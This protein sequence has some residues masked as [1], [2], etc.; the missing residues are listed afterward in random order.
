VAVPEPAPCPVYN[1]A[2]MG[3]LPHSL[4]TLGLGFGAVVAA[5][6]ALAM[7]VIPSGTSPQPMDPPAPATPVAEVPPV[8]GG[9]VT[10]PGGALLV[11]GD[12]EGLLRLGRETL[13][14]RYGLVGDDGGIFFD[15]NP[16]T[17][18]RIQYEGLEFFVGPDDCSIEPGER[19]DPSGVTGATIRCDD[20]EDVRANGTFTFEGTVGVAADLLGMRG[21]IPES[22]GVV[23]V[24]DERLEFPAAWVYIG[25]QGTVV[26]RGYSLPVFDA[27]GEGVIVFDYD[28]QSHELT[29]ESVH[30]D[31]E[32]YGEVPRGGC[33][34]GTRNLGRL[35]AHTSVV[36][37]VI[38]CPSIDIEELGPVP[39]SGTL[40]LE[41]AELR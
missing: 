8:T 5:P 20:V 16:L 10:T 35:N 25:P 31:A 22:G 32:R 37:V 18:A 24:G 13:D 28:P 2:T 9:P 26:G 4:L 29:L 11:S 34:L 21:G 41:R 27:T 19:H 6:L 33:S 1:A 38:D 3:G 40:V 7:T 39:V 12:R 23:D 15:R 14:P 36:E 17:I 30:L